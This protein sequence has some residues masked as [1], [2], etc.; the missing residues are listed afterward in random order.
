MDKRNIN[1]EQFRKLVI[2]EAKQYLSENSNLDKK[3]L[4]N[5][6]SVQGG[7]VKGREDFQ[8]VDD[9]KKIAM[10]IVNAITPELKKYRFQ[11]FT[12]LEK[13]GKKQQYLQNITDSP[14]K[15][16]AL[17]TTDF[18]VG[19]DGGSRAGGIKV[20]VNKNFAP[21]L[22]KAVQ[23]SKHPF[24]KMGN[25]AFYYSENNDIITLIIYDDGEQAPA[26]ATPE[27]AP[28]QAPAQA[29]PAQQVAERRRVTFDKVNTLINE[30]EGM[31]KSISSLSIG[32]DSKE[33]V[34]ES[35]KKAS[36]K[37]DLDVNEHNKNKNIIHVNEGEKDKWN[38]MLKYEVPSD[39]E[40]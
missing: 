25:K 19:W 2:K 31:N 9:N 34:E 24:V 18:G 8:S 20:H 28:E 16:L 14:Q 10:N 13:D 23:N 33:V 30:M 22:K 39:D 7:T 21:Y 4:K 38:R 32:L 17:I 26:Q 35:E 37:R 15:Q 40:R 36:P 1:E 29:A 6:A 3:S 27:Q 12:L 5:E 11:T